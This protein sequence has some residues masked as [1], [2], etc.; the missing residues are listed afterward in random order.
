MEEA[1]TN[2]IQAIVKKV[3]EAVRYSDP[4]SSEALMDTESRITLQFNSLKTA[5]NA[6]DHKAAAETADEIV[7]LITK[8]NS[9]CKLLKR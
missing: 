8:R 9:Q 2:E 7:R 1:Q 5:V 3:F 6:S 4:M